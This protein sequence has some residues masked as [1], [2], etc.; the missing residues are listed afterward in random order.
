MSWRKRKVVDDILKVIVT[1]RDGVWNDYI[2]LPPDHYS[3]I[4]SFAGVPDRETKK[5]D[6]RRGS[7]FNSGSGG[8]ICN[9]PTVLTRIHLT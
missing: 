4:E 9:V 7:T 5:V 1:H 6:P 3:I 2:P 8:R